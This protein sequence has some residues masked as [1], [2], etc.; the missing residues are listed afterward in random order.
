[1]NWKF[2]LVVIIIVAVLYLIINMQKKCKREGDKLGVPYR[3]KMFSAEPVM[4]VAEQHYYGKRDGKCYEFLDY[5]GNMSVRRVPMEK[6]GE[7]EPIKKSDY[8][9]DAVYT[10]ND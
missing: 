1:M 9:E 3:C 5:G 10:F 8:V 6:C 7:R 2:W 4:V